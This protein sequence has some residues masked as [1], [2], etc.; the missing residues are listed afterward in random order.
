MGHLRNTLNN[1]EYLNR[2]S[3][4]MPI[5]E[6]RTHGK[7]EMRELFFLYNDRLTP[8][9]TKTSCGAC[10]KRVYNRMVRYFNQLTTQVN[11]GAN[12]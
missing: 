8:R 7:E 6:A 2:L 11:G 5:L 4:I 1:E 3:K 10:N 9:E 12:G